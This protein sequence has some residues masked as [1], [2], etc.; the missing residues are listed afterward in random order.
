M[1]LTLYRRGVVS[2]SILRIAVLLV[3]GTAGAGAEEM[4]GPPSQFIGSRVPYL[5]WSGFYAGISGGYAW[6]NSSVTYVANDPAAQAG[7]GTGKTLPSTDFTR[8]GP[9]AGGQIGFNWQVNSLW[10]VGAETDYQWSNLSGNGQSSFHLTNVGAAS[11]LSTMNASQAVQSFGTTR[12]RMGVL[13]LPSLLLYGTGGVAYAQVNE[14]LNLSPAGTG[15]L[16]SGT[17]SYSCAAGSVCFAGSSGDTR[18][19]WAAGVGAEYAILSNVTF[20]TEIMYLYLAAPKATVSATALT[21]GGP[22]AASYG[23]TFSAVN[24]TI[25]RFGLNYRF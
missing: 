7:L 1:S 21:A 5:A 17:F 3:L 12:A 9:F 14:S 10:L 24:Y 20:R 8:D 13:L 2:K 11:A 6:G 25:A 19:G 18:F 16:T 22:V 23:A 4:A 15:T